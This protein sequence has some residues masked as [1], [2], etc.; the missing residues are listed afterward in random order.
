MLLSANASITGSPAMVFT[1]NNESDRLSSIEKSLPLIPSTA[2]RLLLFISP[3]PCS[4]I[5]PVES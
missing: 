5:A 2:K 4:T 1:E 3:E